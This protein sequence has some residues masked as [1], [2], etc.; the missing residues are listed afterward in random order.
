MFY[1]KYQIYQMITLFPV[2]KVTGISGLRL[3]G[4]LKIGAAHL[5]PGL[6]C[7]QR[8]AFLVGFAYTYYT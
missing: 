4:H 7:D 2:R 6:E 5:T 3:R 8:F 1:L